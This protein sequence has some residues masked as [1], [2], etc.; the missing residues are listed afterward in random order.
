VQVIGSWPADPG[1]AAHMNATDLPR[2]TGIPLLATIPPPWV[3]S[4]DTPSKASH[5]PGSSRLELF[6]PMNRPELNVMRRRGRLLKQE[7]GRAPGRCVRLQPDPQERCGMSLRQ[8]GCLSWP[9]APGL[10]TRHLVGHAQHVTAVDASPEV[11][12]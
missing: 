10:W 9:A 2:V 5:R 1:L 3:L 8:D 6:G 7:N 4:I 11:I 12:E